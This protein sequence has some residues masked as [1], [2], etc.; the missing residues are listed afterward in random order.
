MIVAISRGGFYG[1]GTPASVANIWKTYL[2]FVFGFIGV[3]SP[4]YISADGI[5]VGPEHREKACRR[6]AGCAA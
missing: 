4:E 6:A 3:H 5:Q 2:R 1:P